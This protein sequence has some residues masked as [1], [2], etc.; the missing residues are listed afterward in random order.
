MKRLSTFLVLIVLALAAARGASA[1]AFLSL[2]DNQGHFDSIT[3]LATSL[4]LTE[5]NS[6]PGGAFFNSPWSVAVATGTNSGNPFGI[7]NIN[8]HVTSTAAGPGMLIG[9]YSLNDL[10]AG[11]GPHGLNLD[12]SIFSSLGLAGV[13]WQLCVDDTNALG[14]QN[15]ATCTLFQSASLGSL[16]FNPTVDGLFSLTLVTRFSATGPGSFDVTATAAPEPGTLLLVAIAVF[17]VVVLR[18]RAG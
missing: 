5:D 15:T 11:A 2:M 1:T 17:A 10:D 9:V 16:T 14:L 6:T 8:I 12:T 3:G 13:D 7:P 18:R 4:T